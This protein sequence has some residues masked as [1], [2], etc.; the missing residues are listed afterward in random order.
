MLKL[1]EGDNLTHLRNICDL[2]YD[3]IYIDPPFNTGKTQKRGDDSLSYSDSYD[4]YLEFLVPRLKEGYRI[5]KENGSMFVHLDY[6]ESHYIKIEL[7]KIFGRNNFMNEIVWA[8]DFGGRSKKKYSA[9]HDTIFW[10]VKNAKNY[11][12]NYD[13]LEKIPYMAP[14]FVGPEKTEKG[15]TITDTWWHTIVHTTGKRK[16]WISDTKTTW[17]SN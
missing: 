17:N 16:N 13:E 3:L 15:K 7:D 8:Y 6:R 10:Y 9:K 14:D 12:F 5:L 2:E 4:N 11:C 1:L